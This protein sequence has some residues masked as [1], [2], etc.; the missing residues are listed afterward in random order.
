[1][2]LKSFLE[3]SREINHV[4]VFAIFTCLTYQCHLSPGHVTTYITWR[5]GV[6][7]NRG[8]GQAIAQTVGSNGSVRVDQP[9]VLY[10]PFVPRFARR[11][12]DLKPFLFKTLLENCT[13]WPPRHEI[14]NAVM[15]LLP[16]SPDHHRELPPPPRA[17]LASLLP[18]FSCWRPH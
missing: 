3:Y 12:A 16:K 4:V 18:C 2:R 7:S 14:G 17:Q 9:S 8:V 6:A 10:T 13:A 1:M 5:G 15:K 11:P